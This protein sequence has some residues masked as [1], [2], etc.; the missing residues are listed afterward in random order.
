[1]PK[2]VKIFQILFIFC[3]QAIIYCQDPIK[4]G[5]NEKISIT[6]EGKKY[7]LNIDANEI[8]SQNKVLAISTEPEDY[9]KPAFIYASDGETNPSPDNRTFSS[10]ETGRNIIYLKASDYKDGGKISFFIKPF[11]N[12]AINLSVFVDTAIH[13]DKYPQGFRHKYNLTFANG[14]SDEKIY[15]EFRKKFDRKTSVLFYALGENYNYFNISSHFTNEIQDTVYPQIFE[16][17]YGYIYEIGPNTF[18]DESLKIQFEININNNERDGKRVKNLKI[19]VGYEII[20]NVK[21]PGDDLREIN[22]L[23]HVYGM[24]KNETCYKVKDL[25]NKSAIML[26]NTFTQGASFRIKDANNS[27]NYT[28]NVYNN[29]FIRLPKEFFIEGNYFCLSYDLPLD[30]N[31]TLEN[32]EASYDF[33]IYYEDELAENQMLIM[34]LIGGKIYTHSLNRGDIMVYRNNFYGEYTEESDKKVYSANMLR[35]RGNPKLYGFT[36]E[37]YPDNCKISAEDL[38]NKIKVEKINPLNMY[39]INKRLNAEGNIEIDKDGDAVSELRKQYMTIVSC[40]S[41]ETDPNN[42]ECK[43]TIEINN[44]RDEVQLI[45]ETVFATHLIG[46]TNFFLIRLK[47]VKYFNNIAYLKIH[48]TVLSG[49]AELF[50]YEDW[51]NNNL[52]NKYNFTHIHRKEIITIEKENLKENYYLTVKSSE[53][54]FIKIKYETNLNYKAYNNL[55][56]NEINI[57]PINKYSKTYYNMFNP[58]YRYPFNESTKNNDFYYKISTIDCSMT[59]SDVNQNFKDRTEFEFRHEKNRLYNYLSSYGFIGQVNNFFETSSENEDCGIII[60]NGEIAED[61][62]LLIISDMDLKA[63]I[64]YTY[65]VFPFVY[66]RDNDL[67]IVIEFNLF[68]TDDSPEHDL[69]LVTIKSRMNDVEYSNSYNINSNQAIT[70]NKTS[71]LPDEG[72]KNI[73]GNLYITIKKKYTKRKYYIVTNVR[74]AKKSP[75]YINKKRKKL[76]QLYLRGNDTKYFYSQISKDEKGYLRLDEVPQDVNV[77]AKI[78]E[79]NIKEKDYDWNGRVKLPLSSDNNLIKQENGFLKYD[80]TGKCAEGCE[81]YILFKSESN[82]ENIIPISFYF[83]EGEYED[84]KHFE[85]TLEL[86]PN[87]MINYKIEI[88]RINLNAAGDFIVINSIP[89]KYSAPGFIYVSR[90]NNPSDENYDFLSQKPGPNQIYLNKSYLNTINTLYIGIKAT[91]KTKLKIKVSTAEEIKLE[92]Y[93]NIRY[94]S[95]LLD[96]NI[97]SFT[98]TDGQKKGKILFYSIGENYNYY[99]MTVELRNNEKIHNF[100]VKQMFENGF[101]ALVDFSSNDFEGINE[102]KIF[103]NLNT[104]VELLKNRKVEVGYEHIDNVEAGDQPIE[105]SIFEHVYG[106]ATN[107]T[108]YKVKDLLEKPATMLINI[109]TQGA[110]FRIKDENNKVNY[111]LDVFN[112]YF[113]KLP[114]EFYIKNNYFCFKHTTPFEMEKELYE[115]ISYDFQIYYEDELSNNQMLIM[116]L[117]SGKIYTH[118]LNRGDIIIYRNN[119]YGDYTEGNETKIYS[120]NMQRIRGNPRLYGFTCENY[121]T[122]CN[123][124]ANDL[125]D[126]IKVEKIKPLNM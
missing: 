69:F 121:P 109:F 14:S 94:T 1:M 79:K 80:Q 77:Y 124:N 84:E 67:G 12:T 101:G 29:Y 57:E 48:F 54:S 107:E 30:Y 97:I 73:L 34:P 116:P 122:N 55:M 113:I 87:E 108:C 110:S 112:N 8:D 115:E 52:I 61:R 20:D 88:N 43:Y 89:E 75:E 49:N 58:N 46:P 59:C 36:C 17:G 82:Q 106:M 6:T 102:L 99:N 86:E 64:E 53:P 85:E 95:K 24:A 71:Y 91:A 44:E 7:T 15:I 51:E 81:I 100:E 96:T 74:S 83:L 21:E 42:G 68:D 126:K 4:I 19:E 65:Y 16:N 23:E 25:V 5:Y 117:I 111:T 125:K 10:Q 120:A 22:I 66:D 70:I 105:I 114:P 13:L 33:Q 41:E 50:V 62:P 92:N 123:I 3:F 26:I 60:Q 78:V 38:K 40:E 47:D 32:L 39:Y 37:Q 90:Q 27:V 56:P 28:L 76:H 72:E 45:P 104:D 9:L 93:P 2:L 31:D 118:S 119:F 18:D 11:A 103:I 63:T 35:L 98:K